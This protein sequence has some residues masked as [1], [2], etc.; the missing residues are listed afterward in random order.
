MTIKFHIKVETQGAVV[1]GS[2]AVLGDC[3]LISVLRF[4]LGY[5]LPGDTKA[6][7]DDS[8]SFSEKCFHQRDL[9][10]TTI[11][12]SREEPFGFLWSF[13]PESKR[14]TYMGWSGWR[15]LATA[16]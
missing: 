1:V 9:D 7:N 2:S 13:N 14:K 3:T 4:R 15:R 8:V 16:V 5:N 12:E 11:A 10:A 6:I